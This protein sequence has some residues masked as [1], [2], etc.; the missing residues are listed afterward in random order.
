VQHIT[1]QHKQC[2]H[3]SCLDVMPY[4]ILNSKQIGIVFKGSE[5]KVGLFKAKLASTY[6]IIKREQEAFEQKD[7]QRPNHLCIFNNNNKGRP[8]QPYPPRTAISIYQ[9]FKVKI[10]PDIMKFISMLQLGNKGIN[11][12]PLGFETR[13][14]YGPYPY[15]EVTCAYLTSREMQEDFCQVWQIWKLG[16]I[17]SLFSR[18]VVREDILMMLDRYPLSK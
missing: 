5:Q 7:A 3:N 11:W 15:P 1:L 9:N 8:L 18:K 13:E 10:Q 12:I 14:N 17:S 16:R 2:R 6:I 4:S